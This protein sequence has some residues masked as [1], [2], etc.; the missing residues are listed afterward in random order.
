MER[1]KNTYRFMPSFIPYVWVPSENGTL[2]QN[3]M[4]SF[5]GEPFKSQLIARF[6]DDGSWISADS[7]EQLSQL[8]EIKIKGT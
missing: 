1:V 6:D 8:L 5:K 7:I 3:V 2:I 4:I